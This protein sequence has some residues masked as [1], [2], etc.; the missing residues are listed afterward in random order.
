MNYI[1]YDLKNNDEFLNKMKELLIE[2]CYNNYK[3]TDGKYIVNGLNEADKRAVKLM[4]IC[5]TLK[6]FQVLDDDLE[7]D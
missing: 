6:A 2:K 3:Y 5:N 1:K 4:K 7:D